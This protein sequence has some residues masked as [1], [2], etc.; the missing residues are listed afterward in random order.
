MEVITTSKTRIDS[1]GRL[2]IPKPLRDQLNFAS[3]H[4]YEIDFNVELSKLIIQKINQ[5]TCPI[6]G[7]LI[8]EENNNG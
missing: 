2:Q 4:D 5:T 3:G 1:Q 8:E 6:C 7:K